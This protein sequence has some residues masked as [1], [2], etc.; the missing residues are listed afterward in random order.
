[1]SVYDELNAAAMEPKRDRYGRYVIIPATGGK[2][3]SYTRATTIA[4]TLDDRYNLE[5][6]KMRQVAGMMTYLP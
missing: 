4:E 3:K 6:W 2:A 1:M 5:L